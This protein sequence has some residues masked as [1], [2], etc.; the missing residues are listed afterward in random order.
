MP[1]HTYRCREW[2]T[3]KKLPLSQL[4]WDDLGLFLCLYRLSSL[5]KAAKLLHLDHSTISRR[6][7]Q[8]ELCIGG[9]LFQRQH[10]GLKATELA[11]NLLPY[12]EQM[13]A[14]AQ[15]LQENFSS[16]N[17]DQP[18]GKVRI[19]MMEGIGS[20]FIARHLL[21]LYEQFPCL[22]V[23]L[24]TSSSLVQVQRREADIFLSFFQPP[25]QGLYSQKV[26]NFSLYLYGAQ[27]YLD[28][29]GMPLTVS[30]LAMHHFVDYLDEFV[31]LNAVRWLEEVI[32][33]PHC[34]FRSNSMLAQMTAAASGLGLALLPRFAVM[35][36][37]GLIPVLSESV[38]VKRDLWLSVHHDLQYSQRIRTVMK[39]ISN[40]LQAEKIWL[41]QLQ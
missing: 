22:E 27:N 39:Y 5:S 23:E 24:V 34:T 25:N 33:N 7:S 2:M 15:A 13:H 4:H 17:G 6:L 26:G 3:T 32:A 11:L 20:M 35:K 31:E 1:S 14:T 18:C 40:L 30:D 21:P 28:L 12:A 10:T 29:H 38:V 9:A 19:A 36:E 37:K 8:L 16:T 41:N